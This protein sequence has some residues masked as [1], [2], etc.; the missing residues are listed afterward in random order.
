MILQTPSIVNSHNF[1]IDIGSLKE[2]SLK[3]DELNEN[4]SYPVVQNEVIY[5]LVFSFFY[6]FTQSYEFKFY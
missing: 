1:Y 4:R 2:Q 5:L 6:A 3:I